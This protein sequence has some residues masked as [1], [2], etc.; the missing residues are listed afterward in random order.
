MSDNDIATIIDSARRAPSKNRIYG[1]KILA[2]TQTE[3][4]KELKQELC[5]NITL[6]EEADGST[7]YLK[8]T[9][10]P[11][12][13]I[14]FSDPRPEHQMVGVC[15]QTGTEVY[16]RTYNDV[17]NDVDRYTM[18][19]SSVRDAMISATYAQ[20][21]AEDLGLGSA[22]VACGLEDLPYNS[23]F[24]KLLKEKF[25]AVLEPIVIMCFGPKDQKIL[26]IYNGSDDVI[27]EPYLQGV[28]HYKRTGREES[29]VVNERQQ[30]M[31]IT[32]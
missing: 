4:A 12:V 11:L 6:Y 15:E 10:A 28:T 3:L 17:D 18:N 2:L 1:Y 8:Q 14:Y 5:D 23:K 13:L 16:Q 20:L 7:V 22:F 25:G 29:F 32:L 9:M 21:T 31:I 30:S 24:E 26:N 27:E 19:K